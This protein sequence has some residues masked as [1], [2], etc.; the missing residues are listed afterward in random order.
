MKSAV[1]RFL[2]GACVLFAITQ[3]AL[4]INI[5]YSLTSLGGNNY[6]YQYALFNNGSLGAGVAVGGFDIAFDPAS[7]SE[8]SLTIVTPAALQADWSEQIIPSFPSV[9]ALYDV[10]ALSGGLA[11]GATLSGFAVEF[12]WLGAGLPGA[13]SFEIF[14]PITFAVLETG[15]TVAADGPGPTPAPEPTTTALIAAALAG[16]GLA[17]RRRARNA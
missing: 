5:T 4:A 9:P 17:T 14:D 8:P 15:S 16:G 7:Y 13:Q 6:R 3:S 11:D 1:I 12:E 10:L 2:A